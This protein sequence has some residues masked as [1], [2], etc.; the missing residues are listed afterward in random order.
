[1]DIEA[2]VAVHGGSGEGISGERVRVSITYNL[3]HGYGLLGAVWL[4]PVWV[5]TT[6]GLMQVGDEGDVICSRD[7]VTLR[8]VG[9]DKPRKFLWEDVVAFPVDWLATPRER[10]TLLRWAQE[11]QTLDAEP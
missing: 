11:T 3:D 4:T 10:A 6:S 8:V 9:E 1:V 7:A 2:P 5:Q